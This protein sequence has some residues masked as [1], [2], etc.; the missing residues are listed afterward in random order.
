MTALTSGVNNQALLKEKV[1][2]SN[3][4]ND[5]IILHFTPNMIGKE[6]LLDCI[7]M[8]GR[9]QIHEAIIVHNILMQ[10]PSNVKAGIYCVRVTMNDNVS[11]EIVIKY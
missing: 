9:T 1:T 5:Q 4:I 8:L 7:D 3:P 10:I 11:Q 6:I 2:I